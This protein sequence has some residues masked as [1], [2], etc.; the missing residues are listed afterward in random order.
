[1]KKL[2]RNFLNHFGYEIIKTDDR[3]VSKNSRDKS[4][5]V[6]KYPIIMPGNNIQLANYKMYPDLNGQL[7]R[8]AIAI[9]KKYPGMT[10]VD[11]GANVGDTISIIKSAIDIPVIGIEGDDISYRYLEKNVQ[12]FSGVSS[13]KTYLGDKKQNVRADLEKS[14]W[15]TTIVPKLL[16]EKTVSFKTL[17]EVLSEDKLRNAEIKLL[18]TDVE[19][20]DTI[21]LRGA[22]DTVRKFHPILFFEYNRDN[23]KTINEDGLSTLLSFG[24]Y[25]YN[26][27]AFFDHKGRLLIVTA[28]KNVSEIT[29]LHHYAIGKNNLLGYFDIC[30]FHE[31]DD[32]VAEDFLQTESICSNDHL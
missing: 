16:G 6:G 2:I 17:D 5:R 8:L 11:V 4:V 32:S 14:G 19:G 23:M 13:Y 3:Y 26:K 1:M 10:A 29:Y 12:Q 25:N 30:I 15:N 7:G 9:A 31:N 18:K 22:M 27:V 28:M 20:F 24:D 21:V